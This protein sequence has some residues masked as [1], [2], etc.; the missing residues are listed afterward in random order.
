M[1]VD[2]A[3]RI[4]LGTLGTIANAVQMCCIAKKKQAKRPFEATLLSLSIADFITAVTLLCFGVYDVLLAYEIVS[5]K[6]ALEIIH[7]AALDLS[8]ITSLVHVMYIAVQRLCAVL[9]PV[10]FHLSFTTFRCSLGLLLIWTLSA[11]YC[12]WSA[13]KKADGTPT[14]FIL[15]VAILAC[16]CLLFLSYSCISYKV[17]RSRSISGTGS[18]IDLTVLCNS[19]FVAS[20]FVLCTIPF[21]MVHLS[22][23][24]PTNFYQFIVPS[25]CLFLNIILDPFIYFLF[26]YIR[27]SGKYGLLRFVRCSASERST[28]N[29]LFRSRQSSNQTKQATTE[30]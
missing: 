12:I 1:L 16:A 5:L 23:F 18:P 9:L 20:A 2:S 14:F 25:W 13:V 7:E 19:V 4:G 30:L 10:S 17:V 8:I 15:S 27:A 24:K 3:V 28:T 22:V 21:T 11:I 29:L 26:K 6:R